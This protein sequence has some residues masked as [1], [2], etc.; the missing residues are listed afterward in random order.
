LGQTNE[1]GEPL[2]QFEREALI[3]RH[4]GLFGSWPEEADI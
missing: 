1:R 3:E 2:S 4:C